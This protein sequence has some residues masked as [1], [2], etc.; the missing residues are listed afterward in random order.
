[1]ALAL[2]GAT[3]SKVTI[4]NN[5]GINP[6]R[7]IATIDFKKDCIALRERDTADSFI[8]GI[9]LFHFWNSSARSSVARVGTS[10]PFISSD[11]VW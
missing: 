4:A 3:R 9:L 5:F 7:W 8:S 6:L 2:L 11:N 1:M 10:Q